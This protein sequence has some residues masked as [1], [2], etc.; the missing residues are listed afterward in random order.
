MGAG[1]VLPFEDDQYLSSY[2]SEAPA[3]KCVLGDERRRRLHYPTS[4][5]D[6]ISLY[7]HTCSSNAW[8]D[9]LFAMTS[10]FLNKIDDVKIIF[11]FVVV[12][13]LQNNWIVYTRMTH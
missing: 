3:A 5:Q 9:G 12:F 11:F 4:G 13:F 8:A 10:G 1:R 2:I 7:N 6:R